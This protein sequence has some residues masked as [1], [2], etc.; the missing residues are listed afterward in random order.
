MIDHFGLEVVA[1]LHA[2]RPGQRRGGGPPC[3]RSLED[4][5][6][7][8]GMDSGATIGVRVSVDREKRTATIDFTGTTPQL[9]TN[10]NAPTS[11]VMAAVLY[12]F[13][14]LVDDDI[15][16]NDGCLSPLRVFIPPGRCSRRSTRG[17]RRR[18]RGDVAVDHRC[19]LRSA[20]VQAEGAG[21][22]NNVTFG[23]ERHQYYET[24]ASGSGAGPGST[25]RR[26]SRPT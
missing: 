20:R 22:M 16:L 26:W 1:G 9:D 25:G 18:Q 15:P 11:V 2:P 21:T 24:V 10:F 19:A 5:E 3:H 14:T 8:Y 23:N 7:R 12:V 4:G 17:S 13:R 6:Y